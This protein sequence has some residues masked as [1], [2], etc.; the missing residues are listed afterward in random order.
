MQQLMENNPQVRELMNNPEVMRQS[1]QMMRNP[2]AMQQM[3]RSQ[4]LAMAN[5]ENMPGGFAALSNMYRDVQEPMMDAMQPQQQGT[6]QQQQSSSGISGATG[7]AMP[8]PWA[9]SSTTTTTANRGT[10][11]SSTPPNS[12][13]TTPPNP[14]GA[15]GGN[16]MMMPGGM[17]GNPDPQQLEQYLQ[18][19]ENP[20]KCEQCGGFEQSSNSNLT[21]FILRISSNSDAANDGTNADAEPRSYSAADAGG[22]WP[23]VC[24]F[25]FIYNPCSQLFAPSLPHRAIPCFSS[26][27]NRT[28]TWPT[29]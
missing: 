13:S 16:N 11:S 15:G 25:S 1:L 20:S 22:S 2:A 18:M 5:L 4:D 6:T 23:L 10:T 3:M 28:P 14:W 21:S 24:V 7:T 19:M 26:W 29:S 12:A 9:S 27:L 8:N 17:M